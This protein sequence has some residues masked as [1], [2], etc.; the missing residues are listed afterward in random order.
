MKWVGTLLD[1][2]WTQEGNILN[3]SFFGVLHVFKFISE[4]EAI[5][6]LPAR[7]LPT[8]ITLRGWFITWNTM[9]LGNDNFCPTHYYKHYLCARLLIQGN[10]KLRP[11][12]SRKMGKTKCQMDDCL[13]KYISNEEALSSM[14][15][16][17]L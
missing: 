13:F 8:R 11:P 4:R 5:A 3:G 6:L 7:N 12:I 9:F 1:T 17:T 10:S 16:C 15:L 14:K 2:P